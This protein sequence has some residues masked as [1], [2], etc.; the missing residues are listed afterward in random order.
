MKRLM[1]L[2]GAILLLAFGASQAL[3][4]GGGSDAMGDWDKADQCSQQKGHYLVHL[5]TY[6]QKNTASA[7]RTLQEVGS[8][9]FR[10]EFQSYCGG[11]P[12]TGKRSEEHTS[13][14]QSP[15]N[16]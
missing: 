10:E 3:A 2:C 4:H 6:Q 15:L 13:E 11:V 12:K 16:L 1:S 8:V 9:Q 7:I 14:L 5:T